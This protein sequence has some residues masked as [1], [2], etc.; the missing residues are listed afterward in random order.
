MFTIQNMRTII[1][2]TIR[3]YSRGLEF[4]P[5]KVGLSRVN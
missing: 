2:L 4:T 5:E 3:F 1:I